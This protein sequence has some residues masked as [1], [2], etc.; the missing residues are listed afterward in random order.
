MSNKPLDRLIGGADHDPG[1]DAAFE[2]L[3]RYCEAARRGDD[4]TRE[5]ADLCTHLRNCAACREDA[6]GLLLALEQLEGDQDQ[7]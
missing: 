5:F 6:E 1:C 7:Q 4:V 2:Q 3:D